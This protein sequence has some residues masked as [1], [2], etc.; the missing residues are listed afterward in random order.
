MS[1]AVIYF[2]KK[3]H[4]CYWR[5]AL[6]SLLLTLN[7][8]HALSWCLHCWLEASKL[9][10]KSLEEAIMDMM[11]LLSQ[12]NEEQSYLFFLRKRFFC[13]WC[14]IVTVQNVLASKNSTNT[15]FMFLMTQFQAPA[16]ILKSALMTRHPQFLASIAWKSFCKC[17][18]NK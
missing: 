9:K 8:F 17:R 18:R 5:I 12:G 16:L 11:N 6:L 7:K 14:C 15:Y 2:R 13:W 4:R 3:F 10:P 1:K